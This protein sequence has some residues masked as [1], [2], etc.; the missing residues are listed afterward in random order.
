[1][2]TWILEIRGLTGLLLS[3]MSTR[4][5]ILAIL[6]IA[7]LCF[8]VWYPLRSEPSGSANQAL[9]LPGIHRE[10]EEVLLKLRQ[11]WQPRAR[12]RLLADAQLQIP[13]LSSPLLWLL[14]QSR[15]P[16]LPEALDLA[17]EL[18]IAECRFP[19]L[20]LAHEGPQRLRPKALVVTHWLEPLLAHELMPFLEDR[21][22][23][24]VVAAL[25]CAATASEFPLEDVIQLVVH[26]DVRVCEAALDAIPEQ[27]ADEDL[28]HL[29][30]LANTA[31][32]PSVVFTIRALGRAEIVDRSEA[33][34]NEM[35][36][37]WEPEVR[38]SALEAL[39]GKH[40]P[41]S[42][43]GPVWAMVNDSTLDLH[44]RARALLCLEK[45]GSS[46]PETLRAE[47]DGLHPF[48]KYFAARCL[49]TAGDTKGMEVLVELDSNPWHF[50][51]VNIRD[52]EEIR[53]STRKI[54]FQLSGIR[55]AADVA[56]WEW[57]SVLRELQDRPLP[58][59]PVVDL[60][61]SR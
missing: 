58:P 3:S 48:L 41:L 49:I 5:R 54:I 16:F 1:M 23:E 46:S 50:D 34:L 14:S 8:S 17:R 47:L 52:I 15:H 57:S 24:M 29:L 30:D 12:E 2:K 4:T 21:D 61:A 55:T 38:T 6:G 40:E 31:V 26:P 60:R 11:T 33:F 25:Q 42:D 19:A 35:L 56:S 45:T 59:A 32:G 13:R 53:G 44:E 10:L 20:M 22:P 36:S 37:S 28:D 43:P 39:A 7:V 9:V 51:G 27:F 18:E